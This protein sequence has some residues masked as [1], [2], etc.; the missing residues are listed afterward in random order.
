MSDSG[1]VIAESFGTVSSD[2]SVVVLNGIKQGHS[3][4]IDGN[5]GVLKNDPPC[6]VGMACRLPGEICSPSD[7][8]QF[9]ISQKSAQV[10][11]PPER[12][13][14]GGFYH[15]EGANRSGATNVPGG[16]FINEDIRLFD[17]SFFGINNLEATYMDPQQ[18]KLLEVVFECLQSSGTTMEDVS[19]STTGVYVANFSVDYQPGQ[20]RDPDYLHRYTATGSGATVMS[21]RISHV[22]NLQ[23]PSFTIDTACSSSV[24]ALHQALNAIEMGDCDSAIVASANLIMSPE[25]H[26][27]AAKSGVLSPTGTCHTFDVSADGYGRAEGVNAIYVKRLSSALR[28][29]NPI[30]AIIRGS[31]VNASGRTPG[32]TLPSAEMQE[33]V[34]RKAYRQAGLDF[35]G[36]DYVECHGTGT[37]VGDPIEVEAVGACFSP[38]QGLPLLI[39]SVKTNVG[40]SEGASGLTS[41][42]KVV[43]AFENGQIPPSYG[44]VELSPKLNLKKYNLKVATKVE[45]WPRVVRRASIN[46]FGYGGANGHVI[47]ESIDSYLGQKAL[48]SPRLNGT[49]LNGTLKNS[50]HVIKDVKNCI[51]TNGNLKISTSSRVQEYHRRVVLP[52]TASSRGSLKTTVG[53]ISNVV[54]GSK[55]VEKLENL[56]HTLSRGRDHLQYRTYLLA[57][58]DARNGEF[59]AMV[60]ETVP[61]RTAK[62]LPLAFVFTG[63]GAQYAQMA[64]ELLSQNQH[65]SDTIRCL[66]SVLL[67]LPAPYTPSW[68]LEQTILEGADKNQINQVT[69]SQPACTAIQI[70]TVDLLRSYGIRPISVVGHSS[71]EI[72]AAYAAGLITSSQAIQSAYFRGYAVGKLCSKGSM[73]A[74]GVSA[75][76]AKVLIEENA[77]QSEVRVACVNSPESVTL[78]GSFSAIEH[79]QS[80]LQ[81]D[82]KF[83]RKLETGGRA[84]HSYMMKEIGELYE[85]LLTPVFL[86]NREKAKPCMASDHDPCGTPNVKM[87]SSVGYDPQDLSI[88][89][90]ENMSAAYWRHNLERP[91]QFDAALSRLA[92]D[93][94]EIHLIEIG[95][96][97]ALKGPI[98]QIRKAIGFNE[99]SLPYSPTLVRKED[100]E[101]RIKMLAGTLFTH[102]H[103]LKWDLVNGLSDIGQESKELK[104]LHDLPPYPWDYSG[105]LLW[106]EPR[107]SD[108]MRNR[109]YLRHELLG[110][111]ALTG[112]GIEFTWRNIL[113]LSEIPWLQDHKLE[114]QVVFPGA[115]Y[116]AMAVEAISQITGVKK[117][118]GGEDN[119]GFELRN[120]NITSALNVLGENDSAAKDLELHTT[121]YPRKISGAS[122]SVDWHDFSISSLFWT[123]DRAAVHCTGSIRVTNGRKSIDDTCVSVGNAEGFDLW[124]STSRWYTKWHQEGLCFGPQFQSLTSLRTD[125][126][127]ERREAIAT[128]RITPDLSG[129]TYE[130]YPVHPITIDAGLQAACLSSTAGHVAALKTWLPVFIAECHLQPSTGEAE[131]EIHVKS[132]EMGFSS[133]RIDGT[134]RDAAG[135]LVFDFRDSRISLYNGKSSMPDAQQNSEVEETGREDADPTES[136]PLEVYLQRQPTLRVQWK[137]DLLRIG[138]EAIAQLREYVTNFV[139]EQHLDLRD[140]E[141]MLV[142]GALLELAGHKNPHMRVFLRSVTFTAFDLSELFYAHDPFNRAIWD[143]LMVETLDLYRA[144]EIKELPA[145]VFD[146]TQAAQ[147]YRYFGNKDRVGKVVI[148]MENPEARVPSSPPT[149]LSR[150]DS[151]K[152]YLLIGCLG[153]LGRSLSRWMIS[154]GARHF[155]FLGRSGADKPSARELVTRLEQAKATVTVVCGDVVNLKDVQTAVGACISKGKQIGGVVQAAMGLQE[156]LWTRMPNEAWHTAISPKWSGT[157]NLHNAI[158]GHELDFF[159]LTSSVSGTVGTATESNY[160]SANGFLDAFA[161]WRRCRGQPCVS[162]GLGM[163]SEVGY[164]HENPEI[165]ALLL[166]KGIQPLNEDEFLQVVDLALASEEGQRSPRNA[167]MLTGLEPAAV[168]KL[169]AQGFDV[170]SHGV[171]MEARASLLLASLQAEKEAK[172]RESTQSQGMHTATSAQ[173]A[174]PWFKDVPAALVTGLAPESTA[175]TMEEAILRL[176]KRR[177]SNLILLPI[178]QVDERKPLPH[179]GVDSMIASEF[180]SWFWAIFRVDVPFLDLMS[181]QKSLH[182]LAGFIEAKILQHNTGK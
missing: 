16:Y 90:H 178:D 11:V 72:A 50:S 68:T 71:G 96:H 36:T 58:H 110:T 157:W 37:P 2:S 69:H 46:S 21:N 101:I 107:A 22:F 175:A 8:W 147:A 89:S 4:P 53:R 98:Q 140:D 114:E 64:R 85:D 57:T 23:G 137:P 82:K 177:F 182:V 3:T 171:L 180:R 9:I 12:Y 51:R 61:G 63:Q 117:Q 155:V 146:I 104:I 14:I 115:G 143:R 99:T 94:K 109:K 122:R 106:N 97:S 10:L 130:Y 34:M 95:P 173:A 56:S 153:G 111:A 105:G 169:A 149:F 13:N 86:G 31:A 128:A 47:L 125:S 132:E 6:I 136:N 121:M 84:Y 141:S 83:A 66:D 62:P 127:R 32:I 20:T 80:K 118:A 88:I 167:H 174:A 28:D 102:G 44:V 152:T 166:R 35:D 124:S 5:R 116:I 55:S 27:G 45:E 156:A 120:V 33:I 26:I 160:C 49:C 81:S 48:P 145:K 159:L 60:G 43:M 17:N 77:L 158:E 76:L 161:Q 108:E 168:R 162:V 42:L 18:R 54:S 93:H 70:A 181:L 123:S 129:G 119:H 41:I 65:F 164:L 19:G 25:L 73:M 74:A 131:G 78:S 138:Q 39:G 79:L 40:H 103:A 112:N 133:R 59:T 113:K 30:R 165:E 100:A 135:A 170:T 91:V 179:F 92:V 29:G 38:R 148:S 126:V 154:R 163:I 75:Q 67:A 172:E 134:I 142:I 24:Y 150:F 52:V 139:E 87:Y 151:E 7:L 1:S 144:G 176:M 15:P